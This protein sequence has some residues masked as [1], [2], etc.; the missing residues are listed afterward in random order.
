MESQFYKYALMRNFI[1]EVVEQE[2]IEKYIQERLNDDH[3]M[4]NRFCN[5]DSDK[6]RELIE[7]VIEYISMGKGKGKEDLIL[8]SILSVCGNEK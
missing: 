3:E 6:I 5:E 7:E 1:R 8:K 4:K 2:S